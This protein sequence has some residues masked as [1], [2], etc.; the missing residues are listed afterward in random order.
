MEQRSNMIMIV[1][2]DGELWELKTSKE[3]YITLKEGENE[4]LKEGIQK[5]RT[6]YI[7]KLINAI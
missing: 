6:K 7:R 3:R 1:E 4:G 2:R 5:T